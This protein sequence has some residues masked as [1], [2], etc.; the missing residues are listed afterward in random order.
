MRS[1]K[2]LN[3]FQF[4]KDPISMPE[5]LPTL[6]DGMPCEGE[7]RPGDMDNAGNTFLKDP[8]SMLEDSPTLSDGMLHKG[9]LRPGDTDDTGNTGY[10]QS[11]P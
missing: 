10:R 8:S 11:R 2:T 5:S 4:L 1:V 3:D 7:L 6:S 9:E